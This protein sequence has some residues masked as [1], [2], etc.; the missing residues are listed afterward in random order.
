MNDIELRYD[1]TKQDLAK[2]RN[3]LIGAWT[4][5]L[6][7]SAVPAIL[8][9]VLMFI[10]GS[11][12]P[13][14]VIFFFL[15]IV[16]GVL[17][18]ATGLGIS[19]FLAYKRSDWKR[20]MRERIAADGIRAEEIEWFRH[21]LRS[22][23]RRSLTEISSRD[24]LL[25]DAYRDTLAT[26]LTASRIIKSS[27]RELQLMQRRQ[28]KLKTLKTESSAEFQA[29]LVKDISKIESINSDAKLMLAEAETRLQMIEAATVRGSAVADSEFVLK[30]LS[31]RAAELPLALAEAKMADEIR[32]ELEKEDLDQ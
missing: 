16:T 11:T 32:A 30:K 20:A 19:G 25:A 31:A 17:G 9:F 27:K 12:P 1:V 24:L 4:A 3:L 15:A 2:G 28:N 21:E 5:P 13:V 6:V 8:F 10:F 29:T 18:L 26:R 14:A 7:L 22:N 23:E